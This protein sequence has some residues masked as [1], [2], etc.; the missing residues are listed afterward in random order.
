M[1]P[2]AALLAPSRRAGWPR[3]CAG[4]PS[5]RHASAHTHAAPA[6]VHARPPPCTHARCRNHAPCT[7]AW[8]LQQQT[9][10]DLHAFLPP[11]WLVLDSRAGTHGAC[12]MVAC[13]SRAV[14]AGCGGRGGRACMH[15]PAAPGPPPGPRDVPQVVLNRL[16]AGLSMAAG[17]IWACIF[18]M[19]RA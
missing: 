8:C 17:A 6:S 14:A 9:G 4:I 16:D 1:A 7:S 11:Y 19:Q 15:A 5:C 10:R 3:S 12:G 13:A 2:G 18:P